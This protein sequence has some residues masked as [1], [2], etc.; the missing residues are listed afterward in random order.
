M[1]V[2]QGNIPTQVMGGGSLEELKVAPNFSQAPYVNSLDSQQQQ[3]YG[4]I[5]DNEM[6]PV[7]NDNHNK[8]RDGGNSSPASRILHQMFG[9]S[10]KDKKVAGGI[11]PEPLGSLDDQVY[12]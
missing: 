8:Y 5:D 4:K 10:A 9:N 11:N 1:R 3:N 7:R 6:S 2:E 12:H